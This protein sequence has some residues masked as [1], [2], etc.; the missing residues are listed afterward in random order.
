MGKGQAQAAFGATMQGVECGLVGGGLEAPLQLLV[1]CCLPTI[2][3]T[4]ALRRSDL[5]I[6][7]K[8]VVGL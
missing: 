6:V 5:R 3:P 4:C 8:G 2:H 1:H 7:R